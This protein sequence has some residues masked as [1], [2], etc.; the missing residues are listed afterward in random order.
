VCALRKDNQILHSKKFEKERL[1]I[2]A[3]KLLTAVLVVIFLLH[4]VAAAGQWQNRRVFSAAAA[5][6]KGNQRGNWLRQKVMEDMVKTTRRNEPLLTPLIA[7]P[8]RRTP[9]TAC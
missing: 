7:I 1:L 9:F 3:M 4:A 2:L 5:Y 8:R 6:D